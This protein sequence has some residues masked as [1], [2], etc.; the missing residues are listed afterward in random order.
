MKSINF[1]LCLLAFVSTLNA[2]S[3]ISFKGLVVD[4]SNEKPIREAAILL[5]PVD[6][7]RR[8]NS[9]LKTITSD[10]GMFDISIPYPGKY[11]LKISAFGFSPF[12]EI[13]ETKEK[14][15]DNSTEEK[16]GVY[17]ISRGDIELEEAQVI[18]RGAMLNGLD[19]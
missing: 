13:I 18:S 16:P 7:S 10:K 1:Y 5:M 14:L 2:Y 17:R 3:Q 4:N 19:R 12:T 15:A 9:L 8:G 6:D 11:R